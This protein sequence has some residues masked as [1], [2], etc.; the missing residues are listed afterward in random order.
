MFHGKIILKGLRIAKMKKI[1]FLL[2]LKEIECNPILVS[3]EATFRSNLQKNIGP[4]GVI[5]VLSMTLRLVAFN[6]L[7]GN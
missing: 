1:Y 6:F 5:L 7:N 4:V 2:P 3:Y